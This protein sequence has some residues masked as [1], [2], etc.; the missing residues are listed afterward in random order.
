[1]KHGAWR[2]LCTG[3]TGD[4]AYLTLERFIY[5]QRS[6]KLQQKLKAH[7]VS[8]KILSKGKKEGT[9]SFLLQAE[10]NCFYLFSH[11]C[12]SLLDFWNDVYEGWN[13]IIVAPDKPLKDE[14]Q[15][16]LLFKSSC[17]PNWNFVQSTS[18]SAGS[19]LLP[20]FLIL[21]LTSPLWTHFPLDFP[22]ETPFPL[23][24]HA[25]QLHFPSTTGL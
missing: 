24:Y 1:M 15:I 21:F 8:K 3:E 9:S 7:S 20:C 14:L 5:P 16:S 19:V 10:K 12:S 2:H 13:D 25:Q 23:Y 17:H 6:K 22:Q 18:I 4:G 11:V